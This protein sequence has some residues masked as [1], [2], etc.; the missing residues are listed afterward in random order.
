MT[1]PIIAALDE[2]LE[3]EKVILRPFQEADITAIY[4]TWLNDPKVVRFSNQR[5]L[6]HSEES[7]RQYLSSFIDSDNHFLAICDRESGAMIGTITVYLNKHHRTADIGIMVGN[8]SSW[9]KGF[10]LDAFQTVSSALEQSGFVRKLTAG[11]LAANEGMIRVM[12]KA[13]FEWEA[14]R[15]EHELIDGQPVDVLY[16][17]KFFHA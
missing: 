1:K 16:Y 15:K 11:T 10:G 14:T 4:L 7:G 6:R 3:G 8:T 2:R 17:S 12:K 13:G 9:G 5:F